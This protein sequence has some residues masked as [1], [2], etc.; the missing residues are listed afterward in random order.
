MFVIKSIDS[1]DEE[2]V[3]VI[4]D[5]FRTVADEF[6]LTKESAPTNAAFIEL[7][8][9]EALHQK[10]T[11]FFGGFFDDRLVG[12]VAIRKAKDDLYYMEKLAVLPGFRHR[13]YGRKLVEHAI[14]AVKEVGGARI[15]IGIINENTVLKE[16]YKGIGFV[17]T[18]IRQYPHLPFKVCYME[19]AV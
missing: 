1:A 6:G 5:S 14:K 11:R 10:G 16:W 9:L 3:R 4:R 15:S 19:L 8:S 2:C 12:F 18:G 13:G 7:D 17:E